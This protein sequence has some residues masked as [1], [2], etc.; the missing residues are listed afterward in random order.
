MLVVISG[1][2]AS[3]K[4]TLAA[5]LSDD[6]VR[7]SVPAGVV[8]VDLIRRS[9][10]DASDRRAWCVARTAAGT[11]GAMLDSLGIAAVVIEGSFDRA[12]DRDELVGPLGARH[13]LWVGLTVTFDE[14]LRRAQADPTRGLSRDPEFLARYFADRGGAGVDHDFTIDTERVSERQARGLLLRR[15]LARLAGDA[16]GAS[17]PGD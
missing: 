1:P 2:I 3:G 17:A 13:I 10:R 7:R 8:E 15:V 5:G 16:S 11:V 9:L 14:A 12:P 6:L 4:S